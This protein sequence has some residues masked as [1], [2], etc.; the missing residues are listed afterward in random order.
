MPRPP[1]M[2]RLT[3]PRLTLSRRIECKSRVVKN[4]AGSADRMPMGN[5]AAFDIDDVFRKTEFFGH[6]EG[7][8]LTA[9]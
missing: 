3:I 5:G 8:G 7:H 6:G 2:H 4:G 1:P 9:T